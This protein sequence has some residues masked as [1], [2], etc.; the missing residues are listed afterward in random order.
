MAEDLK[1]KKGRVTI[2]PGFFDGE[3]FTPSQKE[4]LEWYQP[5]VLVIV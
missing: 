2:I 3:Y 4:A 1:N 5:L